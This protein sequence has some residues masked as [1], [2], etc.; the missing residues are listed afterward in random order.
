MAGYAALCLVYRLLG[1]RQKAIEIADQG[2]VRL[3]DAGVRAAKGG[4][5]ARSIDHARE[6]AGA[7][8]SRMSAAQRSSS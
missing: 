1:E 4:A 8:C 7:K 3:S 2:I 5:P 6:T